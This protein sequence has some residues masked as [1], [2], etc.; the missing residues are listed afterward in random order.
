MSEVSKAET[1]PVSNTNQSNYYVEIL[2]DTVSP[3]HAL[4]SI[5]ISTA[6]GLGGFLAGKRIF[7]A[8]AEQKMVDSYSLLLG[9]VGC[10]VALILCALLF[11]PKRILTESQI[12]DMDSE[13]LLKSLQVDLNEEYEVIKRDPMIRKEMEDLKIK[14]IFI[15]KE[16]DN[17][18]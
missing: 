1:S 6:L 3:A 8:I 4:F 2:G 16:E 7:P 18:I 11:R 17:K 10:V 9:I 5:L 14:D 13:G 15:P 12:N